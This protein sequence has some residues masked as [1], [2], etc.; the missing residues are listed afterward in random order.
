VRNEA[1]TMHHTTNTGSQSMIISR[2]V[3][4]RTVRETWNL[5]LGSP[6]TECIWMWN[7]IPQLHQITVQR[8]YNNQ[9]KRKKKKHRTLNKH[10]REKI[11]L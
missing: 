9:M 1:F 3:S 7:S 6:E 2:L 11:C 5:F 8:Y 10:E 4:W